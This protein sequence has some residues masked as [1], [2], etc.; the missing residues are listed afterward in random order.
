MTNCGGGSGGN[1]HTADFEVEVW[2]QIPP[3]DPGPR[4]IEGEAEI[5]TPSGVV[6]NLHFYP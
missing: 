6:G 5:D 2:D 3:T 1:T 4:E